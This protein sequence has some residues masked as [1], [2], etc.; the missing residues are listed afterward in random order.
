[1]PDERPH[2]DAEIFETTAGFDRVTFWRRFGGQAVERLGLRTGDRVLD[3]CCGTG[4]S[5]LP[6]AREVGPTGEVVAV[7]LA[8]SQ[9]ERGRA[10]ARAA[11]L[12]N[13]RFVRDDID[14]L[15]VEGPFDAVVCVFGI[16]FARDMAASTRALLRRL[17]PDGTLALT[18][19]G[20]APLDPAS[21]EFR[22]RLMPL[23]P[24]W[25]PPSTSPADAVASEAGLA[26]LMG[27]AGA[28]DV[29]ARLVPGTHA[30]EPEDW[31]TIVEGSAFQGLVARLPPE[32][33][34]TLRAGME[35]WLR[36]ARI[37][38]L[39]ADVVHGVGRRPA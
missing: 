16:F 8:A 36:S 9:L 23:L 22:R 38:A 37:S 28:V 1:M 34:R 25:S 6:A 24:G 2:A 35:G 21:T 17:R 12:T 27:G 4:A 19:W 11:G 29:V 39:R 7:D 13:V 18:V 31:W 14:D 30:V 5:A 33:R 26:A 3:V 20:R 10:N 15:A 32:G